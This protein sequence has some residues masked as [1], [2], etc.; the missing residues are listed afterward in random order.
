VFSA[1]KSPPPGSRAGPVRHRQPATSIRRRPS[2]PAAPRFRSR[3]LERIERPDCGRRTSVG[4]DVDQMMNAV[5]RVDGRVSRRP[6]E[7]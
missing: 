2:S 6:V 1:A 7:R 5:V 3:C 4:H